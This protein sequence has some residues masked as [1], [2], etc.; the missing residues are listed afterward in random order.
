MRC[1]YCHSPL[2]DCGIDLFG[3]ARKTDGNLLHVHF[4]HSFFDLQKLL[5]AA[6]R[7]CLTSY[8]KHTISKYHIAKSNVQIKALGA[9]GAGGD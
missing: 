8:S 5:K 4:N 1:S 2:P 3:A 7:G 6:P 9:A